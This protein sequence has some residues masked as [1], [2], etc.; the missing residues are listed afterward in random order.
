MV[1]TKDE[2]GRIKE[3]HSPPLVRSL[4]IKDKAAIEKVTKRS[5]STR[6]YMKLVNEKTVNTFLDNDA[7]SEA[8]KLPPSFSTTRSSKFL[9]RKL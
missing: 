7:D 9:P 4:S 2:N 8:E 1:K 6:N 3:K 5:Q